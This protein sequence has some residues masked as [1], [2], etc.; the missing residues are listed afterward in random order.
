MFQTSALFMLQYK[1]LLHSFNKSY[2]HDFGLLGPSWAH[3]Q[4]FSLRRNYVDIEHQEKCVGTLK[5][6]RPKTNANG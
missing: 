3:E 2:K 1:K 6:A 4:D 5:I